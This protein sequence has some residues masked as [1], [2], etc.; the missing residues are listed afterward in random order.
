MRQREESSHLGHGTGRGQGG[1]RSSAGE[2]GL[3]RGFGGK[4]TH[5]GKA[6]KQE[7]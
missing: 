3:G 2:G 6:W 7:T 4:H 5:I 1:A